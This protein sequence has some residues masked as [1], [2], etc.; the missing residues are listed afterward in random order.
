M[1]DGLTNGSAAGAVRPVSVVEAAGVLLRGGVVAFPTETVYGLGA[2]ARDDAA[3][4]RVFAIKGRPPS[5]P[6]IV[7]VA[8]P[9]ALA[10]FAAEVPEAAHRLADRFWPGPLT[11]VLRRRAGVSALITGG[12]DTVAVRIPHHPVALSLIETCGEALVGPSAN[13]F[14]HV[15]PTT[16]DHVFQE[17]GDTVPV[18]DG[19]PCQVGIEST[20]IDLSGPRARLLRPGIIDARAVEEVLGEAL[21][22]PAE[23]APRVPGSLVA[24][25]APHTPLCLWAAD[26]LAAEA[27]RRLAR[28]EKVAILATDRV[29]VPPQCLGYRLPRE[30]DAVARQLYGALRQLDE[31]GCDVILAEAPPGAA[32]WSGIRD[33]LRRASARAR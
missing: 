3:V 13:R 11:L 12:Q 20:I 24:H 17:F 14:G 9:G 5:H 29:A 23:D 28:G 6:V 8:D 7:H 10:R 25:Y 27:R 22:G 18:V 16:P 26:G 1:K 33:R 19:G 32:E 30:R 15:S 21:A 31:S 4:Q 2:I